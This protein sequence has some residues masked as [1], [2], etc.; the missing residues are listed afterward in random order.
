[1]SIKIY[2]DSR[3]VQSEIL[4]GTPDMVLKEWWDWA[5]GLAT[6][7]STVVGGVASLTLANATDASADAIMFAVSKGFEVEGYPTYIQMTQTKYEGNVP[8]GIRGREEVLEDGTTNVLTW[9][10]WADQY[11]RT[12]NKIGTKQYIEA[13]DGNTYLKGSELAVLGTGYDVLSVP[14]Y[15]ALLPVVELDA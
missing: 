4:G 9:Q 3:L 12:F 14:E 15:I 1:M 8:A 10:E 6:N 7:V 5:K 2:G 11:G 13:S